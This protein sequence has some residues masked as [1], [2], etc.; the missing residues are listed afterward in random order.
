M[1]NLK[2]DNLRF[3]LLKAIADAAAEELGRL[4]ADHLPPLLERYAEDGS[5]SFRVKLPGSDDLVA[6]VSLSVPKDKIEITDEDEFLTWAELHHAGA[7]H[8]EEI[9]GEPERV[10]V[11]P[12]TEP[13]IER[14]ILP[15]ELTALMKQFKATQ[16]G[17]V[18]LA[19]GVLVEGATLVKGAAPK[20]F[21]VKYEPDGAELLA[22]AYRAGKLDDVVAGTTLPPVGQRP[23]LERRL[24]I[25]PDQMA[26]DAGAQYGAHDSSVVPGDVAADL[27]LPGDVAAELAPLEDL[28][29]E[30]SDG[31]AL[32]GEDADDDFDPGNWGASAPVSGAGW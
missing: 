9:P 11:V 19:T 29:P 2:D 4:R 20:S 23:V 12:A 10:E 13:R 31:Y 16:E 22:G 30:Y 17:V 5:A 26:R 28:G 6:T 1:T 27:D 3:V 8:V 7:V 25:V 32:P 18:D 14:T 15:K 21:S 24:E